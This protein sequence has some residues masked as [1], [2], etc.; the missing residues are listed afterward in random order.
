METFIVLAAVI[1]LIFF[2]LKKN[3][4]GNS[5]KTNDLR[6]SGN[7]LKRYNKVSK[8][9]IQ[10]IHKGYQIY[11]Q[12]MSVEGISFRKDEANDFLDDNNLALKLKT[13]QENV[14]DKNA[15][16]VIGEGNR[17]T[18]FLGYVP[19]E[20]ALKISKTD[21]FPYIYARLIKIY[22]SEKNFID[23]TFQIVGQKDKKE[24]FDSYEKNLPIT[25]NQKD[26]LK[27][28][29][30]NYDKEITTFDAQKII[31]E[32][33]K[34]AEIQQSEK[35]IAWNRLESVQEFYEKFSDKDERTE[36]D[37]KKPT[38]KQIELAIDA[39]LIQGVT[40]E[41]M[42]DDYELLADK[43]IDMFPELFRF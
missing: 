32:H 16:R 20:V 40:I 28:W 27:F 21:C 42:E 14:A 17:G 7:N 26:Y 5:T 35:M 15:I 38:K 13:E 37:I 22:R 36:F 12:N 10:P 39:L 29:G 6:K 24:Q 23:I 4:S 11:F 3:S 2:W 30:I 43:L 34:S 19:K 18:Y 25:K 33:F 31:H 9:L 8:S 41:A 1:A